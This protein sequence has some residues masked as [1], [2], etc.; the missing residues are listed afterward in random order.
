VARDVLPVAV[1][2][3]KKVAMQRPVLESG[4]SSELAR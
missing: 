3:P 2:I 4:T 1:P